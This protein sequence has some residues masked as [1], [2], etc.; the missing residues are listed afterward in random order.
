[1]EVHGHGD[2]NGSKEAHF[3]HVLQH[4]AV[5]RRK[6][7]RH[8]RDTS[9]WPRNSR[10][11]KTKEEKNDFSALMKAFRIHE[12]LSDPVGPSAGECFDFVSVSAAHFS[13]KG[14]RNVGSKLNGAENL[15][16]HSRLKSSKGVKGTRPKFGEKVCETL[17]GATDKKI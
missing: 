5:V 16:A 12:D 17:N 2:G 7:R 1:M 13:K 9:Q 14:V 15:D 10:K 6:P 11:K 8:L 4:V 3:S